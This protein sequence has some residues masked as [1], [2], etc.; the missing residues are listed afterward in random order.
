M[1][2]GSI[3]QLVVAFLTRCGE[4]GGFIGTTTKAEEFRGL[5]FE[6]VER[7]VAGLLRRG[8]VRKEGIRTI[9]VKRS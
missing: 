9:L 4:N 5:D 8:I 1:R 6:Q 7:A 3:Q 2:L